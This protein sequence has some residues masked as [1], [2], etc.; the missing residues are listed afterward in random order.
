VAK[1]EEVLARRTDLSTFL[2]HLCRN[3][4]DEHGRG[5]TAKQRL[6][7]ILRDESLRAV[8]PFGAAVDRLNRKESLD[9]QRCVCFTETPLEHVALLLEDIDGRDCQFAPYGVA[10]TKKQGRKEG[11]NPVWYVDIT[12]GHDWLTKPLNDL[13]G[14]AIKADFSTSAIAKLTPFVEQMGTGTRASD[15]KKY[16]KEFWWEREWRC[17]GNFDLPDHIIV[18]CPREEHEDFRAIVDA[19]TLDVRFLDPRWS[20]EQ[21]IAR[22]AGFDDDEV[23]PM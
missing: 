15:G 20:L 14:A 7:S 13:V 19:G 4:N 10:I 11:L 9:S 16:R 5:I 17:V 3:G 18:L 22:L 2:V 12:P 6:E 8:N 23:G 21:I 1:V